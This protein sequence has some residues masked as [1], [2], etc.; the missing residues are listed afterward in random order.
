MGR[1]SRGLIGTPDIRCWMEQSNFHKYM[2]QVGCL[3]KRITKALEKVKARQL[4]RQAWG[5][6]RRYRRQM[7][8][9]QPEVIDLTAA[10]DVTVKREP[11]EAE[12]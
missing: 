1:R 10:A 6:M 3:D 12:K 5:K 9:K 8:G 7:K 4:A 11:Q 2:K